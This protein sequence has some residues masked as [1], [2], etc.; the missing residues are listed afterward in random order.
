MGH[1]S[2]SPRDRSANA[3]R[4]RRQGE[5]DEIDPFIARGY[6]RRAL[7]RLARGECRDR[8]RPQHRV[9]AARSAPHPTLG[10][11]AGEGVRWDTAGLL[12]STPFKCTGSATEALKTASTDDDT[13][14]LQSDF[15]RAGDGNDESFH[16]NII[17]ADDDIAPDVTGVQNVWVQGV[18]CATAQVNFGS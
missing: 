13:V 9:P 8:R 1:G 16:A 10:C 14:V 17:V 18:G 5:D 15:Y 6:R 12:Q 3:R 7:R 2:P 11:L 4:F